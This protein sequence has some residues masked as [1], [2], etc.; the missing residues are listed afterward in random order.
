MP[1][2]V[3]RDPEIRECIRKSIIDFFFQKDHPEIIEEK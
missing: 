3:G 2:T 1:A